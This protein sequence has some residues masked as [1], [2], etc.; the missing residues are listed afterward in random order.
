MPALFLKCFMYCPILQVSTLILL[1]RFWLCGYH[2]AKEEI[3]K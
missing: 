1:F 3:R 2:T